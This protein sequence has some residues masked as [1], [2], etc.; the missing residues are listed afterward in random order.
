MSNLFDKLD[1]YTATSSRATEVKG[2]RWLCAVG[3]V[4]G[5]L[6]LQATAAR[7]QE[8]KPGQPYQGM[9]VA[10]GTQGEA[11]TLRGF[12]VMGDMDKA[13]D[14]LQADDNSCAIG[15]VRFVAEIQVGDVKT[16][17]K[18]N[19]WKIVKIALPAADAYLVTTADLVLS[20]N[21]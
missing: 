12:V 14:Y 17:A 11:E 21:T 3:V 20:D 2:G 19:T 9:I 15:P 13:K 16:D 7:A 4:A 6:M 10:C 1:C 8:M 5:L 18:G